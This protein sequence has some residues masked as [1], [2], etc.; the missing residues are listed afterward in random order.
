MLRNKTIITYKAKR[1]PL[2]GASLPFPS[3]HISF[4]D[5]SLYNLCFPTVHIILSIIGRQHLQFMCQNLDLRFLLFYCILSSFFLA[6]FRFFDLAFYCLFSFFNFV[7]IAL[8]FVPSFS[9]LFCP[10]FFGSCGFISK[11]PQLAW[12]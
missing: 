7:F 6:P 9:L 4:V 11:L 3:R 5:S 10:C 1:Q 2:V 12:E 8:C